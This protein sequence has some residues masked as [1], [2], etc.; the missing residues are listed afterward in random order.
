MKK[1]KIIGIC[2]ML[3]TM[4]AVIMLSI[5]S[6]GNADS[7]DDTTVSEKTAATGKTE[8]P[9]AEITETTGKSSAENIETTGLSQGGNISTGATNTSGGGTIVGH[10]HQYGPWTTIKEPTCLAMGVQERIC[11][12]GTMETRNID[13]IEHI[14]VKDAAKVATCTEPGLTEGSHC[15]MCGIVIQKQEPI[16]TLGHDYVNGRCSRCGEIFEQVSQG[17]QYTLG[18]NGTYSYYIVT[19]I[20]TCKDTDIVI[21]AEYKGLPV[22]SIGDGAFYRCISLTSIEIPSSVTSIGDSTFCGCSSLTSVIFGENSRLMSIK[23][24]AFASCD[25]LMSIKIPSSVTSIGKWTF[26]G[27]SSLENIT[28]SNGNKIYHSAGNCLIET[29]SKTLIVGCKSSIIPSDGSVTR[30]GDRAFSGCSGLMSVKIPNSVNGIGASAFSGCNN[31]T[32]VV[33]SNGVTII[34]AS[35]FSGCSNLTSLTIPKSVEIIYAHAFEGCTKLNCVTFEYVDR[36]GISLSSSNKTW[37][38]V[39]VTSPSRNAESLTSTYV[40]YIWKKNSG[41]RLFY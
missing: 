9:S 34:G 31:L 28:I 24:H 4:F 38:A 19:G 5:N 37:N 15:S 1:T 7:P 35:A 14:I 20:G 36:W 30:I 26:N 29:A 25:S 40:E 16:L 33:I 10:T 3:A 13:K 8:A 27:C 18:S 21:P 32:S 41:P 23:N 6:C 17:L 12:C 22:T 11:T 39:N 2:V